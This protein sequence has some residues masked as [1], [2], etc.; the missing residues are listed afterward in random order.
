[1]S[2]SS[3]AG[4]G[5]ETRLL[6]LV[7]VVAV[8]MLLL[9]AQ[10]RFPAAESVVVSPA[11]GPIERLAARATFEDLALVIADVSARVQP[12]MVSVILERVPPPPPP[13]RKTPRQSVAPPEAVE[14]RVAAGIRISSEMVLIHL[15]DQFQV[16]PADAVALVAADPERRLA[17]VRVPATTGTVV[18]L[19]SPAEM[20]AGPG[21]VAL[22]EGG[23][24]GAALRPVFIG[25][26]DP[27]DDIRWTPSPTAIG[28]EPHIAAGAFVFSLDGRL[29]GMTIA[30]ALGLLVVPAPALEAAATALMISGGGSA[31]AG[32][33]QG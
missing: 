25:R 27:V 28:G 15:P 26:F 22:A 16:K 20:P 1:M 8:A 29:I 23:R 10:F 33:P 4:S 12:S 24:L 18:G 21:Y 6:L 2:T 5:R 9:L 14:T 30:D 32:S 11:S 3:T 13:A 19:A 17:L 7:I 31:P